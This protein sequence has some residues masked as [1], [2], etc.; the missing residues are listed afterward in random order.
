MIP[1]T[2]RILDGCWNCD[3]VFVHYEY[4][5]GASFYCTYDGKKRP[6][7]GSVAMEEDIGGYLRGVGVELEDKKYDTEYIKLLDSWYK[8]SESHEV[9]ESGI[10]DNHIKSQEN[11]TRNGKN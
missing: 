4:D 7:C 6:L 9:N 8:W 3:H 10:C 2:Y 5:E 11:G 1:K